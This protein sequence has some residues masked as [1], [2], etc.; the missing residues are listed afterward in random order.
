MFT[1]I[2]RKHTISS[3]D[4]TGKQLIDVGKPESIAKA[5]AFFYNYSA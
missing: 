3:Y 4:H 5:E 1:L 2:L